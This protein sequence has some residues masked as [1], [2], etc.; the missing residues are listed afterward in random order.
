MVPPPTHRPGPKRVPKLL[1]RPAGARPGVQKLPTTEAA[2]AVNGTKEAVHADT[3]ASQVTVTFS[4]VERLI[5]E[6]IQLPPADIA[7]L[8]ER[9]CSAMRPVPYHGDRAMQLP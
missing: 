7:K 5:A 8:A 6:R 3:D 9:F 4:D 2:D 1:P